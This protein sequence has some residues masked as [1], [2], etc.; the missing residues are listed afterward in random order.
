MTNA[1]SILATALLL[2]GGAA[3]GHENQTSPVPKTFDARQVE[4]T[5]FGQE[6]DPKKVTRTVRV[7]MNDRM[8]F[9][10]QSVTVRKGETIRF[11]IAN[12]GAV[13]HEMVLGTAQALKEHAA[14][15]KKHPGMKHDEPS[16]AHVSPGA[17]GE[18]VWQFTQSGEFQFACL[19]P[20]H[21]EAGMI[22][23][24]VVQ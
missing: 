4:A 8:R 21:F 22:G 18:I 17:T 6:G 11:I 13:L 10:P 3:L 24:V 5:P 1:A 20:G 15:M 2:V 12:R 9:E 7:S 23:K 16:M 14:L 19:V